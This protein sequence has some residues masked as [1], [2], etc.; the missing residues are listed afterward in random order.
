MAMTRTSNVGKLCVTL[1]GEQ[2]KKMTEKVV[3]PEVHGVNPADYLTDP[4]SSS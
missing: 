4:S 2:G 3:Y 1:L